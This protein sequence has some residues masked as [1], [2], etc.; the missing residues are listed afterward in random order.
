M[1]IKLLGEGAVALCVQCVQAS[2][3][4]C[5]KR[6][7]YGQPAEK[8]DRKKRMSLTV[9]LPLS[10]TS[11][12]HK[13]PVHPNSLRITNKSEM[14]IAPSS[15]TSPGQQGESQDPSSI[16]AVESKLQA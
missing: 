16:V 10:S 6:K 8:P 15:F 4:D 11:A 5:N 7:D 3:L 2:V 13:E 9:T 12:V 1:A 14:F